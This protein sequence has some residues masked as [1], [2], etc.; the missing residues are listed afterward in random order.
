MIAA[1]NRCTEDGWLVAA[2]FEVP[3]APYDFAFGRPILGCNHL[4]CRRC[5]EDVRQAAGFALGQPAP[6]PSE[7]F[8]HNDWAALVG[9]GALV[10]NAETRL[11]ACSCAV[12]VMSAD[13]RSV[14]DPSGEN[15]VAPLPSGWRCGGHP[16]VA[17]PF[18]LDGIPI[19]PGTDFDDWVSAALAGQSQGQP[20]AFTAQYASCETERLYILLAHTPLAASVSTAVS[21]RLGDSSAETRIAAAEFFEALPASAG[22]EQLAIVARDH[23]DSWRGVA[24]PRS[25]VRTLA[26]PLG[27][28]LAARLAVRTSAGADADAVIRQ[29]ARDLARWPDRAPPQL[30]D[31][32]VAVD[33]DWLANA[34]P[35][36]LASTPNHRVVGDLLYVLAPSLGAALEPVALAMWGTGAVDRET[37]TSLVESLVEPPVKDRIL[38]AL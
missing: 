28:A 23:A 18:V 21:K 36:V 8:G 13:Y 5:G 7:L 25:R 15:E 1:L 11:Y 31:A 10:A 19:G 30:L 32:L 22:A 29:S 4:S 16:R 37:F 35:D 34:A 26:D 14:A 33:R 38:A 20:P 9:S 17:V 2:E 12:F 27:K 6:S 3:A 24:H